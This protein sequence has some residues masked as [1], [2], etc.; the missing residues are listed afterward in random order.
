MGKKNLGTFLFLFSGYHSVC[1]W[2]DPGWLACWD[3]YEHKAVIPVNLACCLG[4]VP[5]FC[6]VGTGLEGGWLT[7]RIL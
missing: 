6:V 2:T 4:L 5:T 7:P 3:C 1:L